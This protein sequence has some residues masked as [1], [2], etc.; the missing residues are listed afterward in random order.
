M[1]GCDVFFSS[2]NEFNTVKC[3]LLKYMAWPLIGVVSSH[4][5]RLASVCAPSQPPTQTSALLSVTVDANAFSPNCEGAESIPSI[6][7]A[8][9]CPICYT[10]DWFKAEHLKHIPQLL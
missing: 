3:S 1:G 10:P 5:S 4:F 2:L 8:L 7:L 9:A 6:N